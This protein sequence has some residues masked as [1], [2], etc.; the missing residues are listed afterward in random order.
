M[1]RKLIIDCDP[2]QDDCINLFMA[3]PHTDLYDILGITVVAG[4][5]SLEKV[6]RNARM[7]CEMSNRFDIP[8]YEGCDSP[9]DVPLVTAEE[10]HSDEGLEGIEVFEPEI[11]AQDKH[12]VDFIID[13][14]PGYFGWILNSDFPMYTKK[15]LT[16]LRLNK[17]NN[18]L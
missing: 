12:A 2:G 6:S 17:L 5:V 14:E 8:V 13:N 11:K 18:K 3:L 4:N 16:K 15:I 9:F 1:K 10:V 7:I